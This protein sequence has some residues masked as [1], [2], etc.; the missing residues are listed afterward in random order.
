MLTVATT[1]VPSPG[2]W[3]GTAAHPTGGFEYEL[4]RALAERFGLGS[5]RIELVDFN[6]IVTGR[7]GGA[8]LAL[9]LITPTGEREQFLDFSDPYLDAAPTVV[10]RSGTAVPDLATAQDLRW[11]VVRAT[12]FVNIIA[13]SIGPDHPAK[14]YGDT[15][16]VL[17][18]LQAHAIDAVLLDMPLA[19][20]TAARSGGRLQAVAQLPTSES[21][22]AGLPKGSSNVDA[23]DSAMRALSADGTTHRLIQTWLGS[24]AASAQSSI[25]LLQTTR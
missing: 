3:E 6:R 8:D 17:A 7:L 21:I 24:E 22:A 18:A 5:V 20:V 15:D 25:P 14:L 4:A 2:F 1:T 9:D 16:E 11:G 10:V 13:D 23:V 12:T 19:V